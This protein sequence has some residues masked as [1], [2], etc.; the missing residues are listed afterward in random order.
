[1]SAKYILYIINFFILI[2]IA[3]VILNFSLY[4]TDIVTYK[5]NKVVFGADI[6]DMQTFTKMGAV[7]CNLH[8]YL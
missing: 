7:V 6:A 8:S 3:P 2:Y 4:T 1:M 5:I